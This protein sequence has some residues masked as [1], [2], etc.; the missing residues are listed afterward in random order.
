MA[1]LCSER[2][3]RR[4]DKRADSKKSA[5]LLSLVVGRWPF[6]RISSSRVEFGRIES[7]VVRAAPAQLRDRRT[8]NRVGANLAQT[9]SGPKT[10]SIPKRSIRSEAVFVSP[11]SF[12]L[13][14]SLWFRANVDSRLKAEAATDTDTGT[15]AEAEAETAFR[16][17]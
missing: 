13:P 6:S 7:L 2:N 15:E 10:K 16:S 5:R 4:T 3:R 11:I 17:V 1:I 9:L 14:R 12:S 8:L